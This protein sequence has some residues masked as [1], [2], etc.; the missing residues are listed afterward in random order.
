MLLYGGRR[1]TKVI[2]IRSIK[3]FWVQYVNLDRQLR[4]LFMH[5]FLGR[6]LESFRR[7]WDVISNRRRKLLGV[8]LTDTKGSP[9]LRKKSF[10]EMLSEVGLPALTEESLEY[11]G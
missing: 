9:I 6:D 10:P 11:Q 7:S 3:E 5:Y 8:F 4:D 2:H 1:R